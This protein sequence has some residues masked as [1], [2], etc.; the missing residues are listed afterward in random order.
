MFIN[1][2]AKITET[3]TLSASTEVGDDDVHEEKEDALKEARSEENEEFESRGMEKDQERN[4]EATAISEEDEG[5]EGRGMEK[6]QERNLEATAIR[7]EKEK[8]CSDKDDYNSEENSDSD[9]D[10]TNQKKISRPIETTSEDDNNNDDMESSE[11][12]EQNESVKV[13]LVEDEMG[14]E[15]V[16][17]GR[18]GPGFVFFANSSTDPSTIQAHVNDLLSIKEKQP[19]LFKKCMVIIEDDGD[20][21]GL[22]SGSTALFH[23]RL[24]CKLD[25]EMLLVVKY[26]PGQS[27]YNPV[28]RAWSKMTRVFGGVI[29]R[30][31]EDKGDDSDKES[32][33]TSLQ[34]VKGL[35]SGFTFDGYNWTS[36]IVPPEEMEDMVEIEG[37][38]IKNNFYSDI[39]EVNKVYQGAVSKTKLKNLANENNLVWK[40]MKKMHKHLDKRQHAL[41]FRRCEPGTKMC[42]DCRKRKTRLPKVL[43]DSLPK[44]K[45]G[46]LFYVPQPDRHHL[47]KNMTYLDQVKEVKK[48][49]IVPDSDLNNDVVRCQVRHQ[50][51]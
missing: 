6:D 12:P 13:K 2:Q 46:G 45:A 5:S 8:S 14:R 22:K 18:T 47:G 23:F 39:D 38:M 3:S 41:V 15:H 36:V 24:F 44:K 1:T 40:E 32:M 37:S 48:M 26:A 10:I 27:R 20:D 51:F 33:L 49:K 42:S 21:Y 11:E 7:E 43:R 17:T 4:V 9:L 19:E 31:N 35:M 28:E 25:L 34:K 29:L 16:A 50:S 30:P